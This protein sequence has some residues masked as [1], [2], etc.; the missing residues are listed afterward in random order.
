MNLRSEMNAD[1]PPPFGDFA[2]AGSQSPLRAAITA[3][4]RRPEPQCVAALIDAARL[5]EREAAA[6]HEL[7]STL[8]GR[9][10]ARKKAQLALNARLGE[11]RVVALHALLDDCLATINEAGETVDG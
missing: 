1:L 4:T 7:A 6:A 11:T 9:L 8:A 2:G 3:A 5:P 10:R